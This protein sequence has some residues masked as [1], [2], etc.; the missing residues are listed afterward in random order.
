[1]AYARRV[2]PPGE[3]VVLLLLQ[4]DS[5]E[6]LYAN[7]VCVGQDHRDMLSRY[8]LK[9]SGALT[10]YKYTEQWLEDDVA[11]QQVLDNGEFPKYLRDLPGYE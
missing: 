8:L 7:G 4:I 6:A 3:G 10:V 2:S 9:Q 1:M 11:A 5:W